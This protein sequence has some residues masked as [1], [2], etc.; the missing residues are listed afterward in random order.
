MDA[1]GRPGLCTLGCPA[2]ASHVQHS[3]VSHGARYDPDTT[4]ALPSAVLTGLAGE[5][6]T[7]QLAPV[8]VLMMSLLHV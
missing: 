8:L 3:S 4:A 7:Q 1:P 5:H 6:S 2:S